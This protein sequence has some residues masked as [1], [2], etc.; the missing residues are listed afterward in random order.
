MPSQYRA[1]KPTLACYDCDPSCKTC[2][3][4]SK[5]DCS[6]C[7]PQYL[8]RDNSCI[9]CI[10]QPGMTESSDPS[11]PGCLEICG[12]GF[13]YGKYECDDGNLLNGDG[14]DSKCKVEAGWK[15][16]GG[17]EHVADSCN[18]IQQPTPKI[19]LINK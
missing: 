16:E 19:S 5:F 15:C 2:E 9:T 14:C 6:S 8:F 13:N 18:D 7:K 3:G 17:T 10:D 12:D 4:M 1:V 11:F